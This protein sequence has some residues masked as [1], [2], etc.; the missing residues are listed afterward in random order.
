MLDLQ[1][2]SVLKR[3]SA[4]ILDFI[5]LIICITGMALLLSSILGYD[6]YSETIDKRKSEIAAEYNVDF[7][8]TNDE[9]NALSSESK[10]KFD[11]AAKVFEEDPVANKA[12]DIL[13]N[14]IFTI[15]SLSVLLSYIITEFIVPLF[16][17][18]GQTIGKKVFSL[19][20]MRS[21]HVKIST[22]QLFVR[23]ILGK[24]TIE[25]M[26]PIYI[27]IMILFGI[28]GI[29]GTGI[30]FL[31]LILQICLMI[32]TKNNCVIHDILSD[33]VVVDMTSQMIFETDEELL[34][35]QKKIHQ[36]NVNSSSY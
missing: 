5:V 26:V 27:F 19:G 6:E 18:N 11:A 32:F 10:E 8:I 16:L 13:V 3:I 15:I 30:L 22:F 24:C 31:L 9:Y 28:L 34:E 20:V 23:S 4:F 33:T 7:T 35:Y 14:L 21:H 1:K 36:E 25:T 2:A 17:G 12:W 29:V